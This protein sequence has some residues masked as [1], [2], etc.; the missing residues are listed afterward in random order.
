MQ[1]TDMSPQALN[2]KLNTV[3]TIDT[4]ATWLMLAV[5]AETSV[6]LEC[7]PFWSVN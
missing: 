2:K 1:I 6:I 7:A 4:L 3:E 5:I